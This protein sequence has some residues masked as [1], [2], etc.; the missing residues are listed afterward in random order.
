[1]TRLLLGLAGVVLLAVVALALIWLAGQVLVGVGALAVGT[2][3]V[4]LKLLW[5]LVVVTL[6]GGL[7]YFVANAWRPG[8]RPEK[9]VKGTARRA[10]AERPV[11]APTAEAGEAQRAER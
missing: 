6:L 5:F 8:H 7:V 3:G 9:T 2:A 10:L 1:M 11:A 4:L